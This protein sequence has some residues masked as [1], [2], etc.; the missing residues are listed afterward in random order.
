V[1]SSIGDTIVA[2]FLAEVATAERVGPTLAAE[3]K[4]L[5]DHDLLKREDALVELYE[6]LAEGSS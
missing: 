3:L 2:R 5:I 4:R 6:R 1:E